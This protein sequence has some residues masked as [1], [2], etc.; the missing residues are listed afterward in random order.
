MHRPTK[1][2]LH[3]L[4]GALLSVLLGVTLVL[5]SA[6]GV[7]ASVAWNAGPLPLPELGVERQSTPVSCGP[8]VIATLATWLGSP[9]T[10][11]EVL[12]QT[13]LGNAGV[14]L[15]EFA[16][17]AHERGLSGSWFEVD[18]AVLPLVPVPFAAHLSVTS[19][20]GELGHVV[21]ISSAAYGY[22]VVADPAEG[23]YVVSEKKFL[24][25]FTGRVYVLG[26]RP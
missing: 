26:P 11:A 10:E 22:L 18:G 5:P 24:E 3:Y 1:R 21:A 8:A 9:T 23:G 6:R 19:D 4:H 2:L 25:R 7:T 12:S 17:L 16:R 13:T 20:E 15:S 14:S